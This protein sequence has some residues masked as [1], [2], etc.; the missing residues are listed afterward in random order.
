EL[1]KHTYLTRRG[2]EFRECGQ[3]RIEAFDTSQFI[4]A[5]QLFAR[6][7]SANR[8]TWILVEDLAQELRRPLATPSARF[9]V[10]RN[11]K[12]EAHLEMME[13]VSFKP[14]GAEDRDGAQIFFPEKAEAWGISDD[15]NP[16]VIERATERLQQHFGRSLVYPPGRLNA[17]LME[18]TRD[19]AH[20]QVNYKH[21]PSSFDIFKPIEHPDWCK[22]RPFTEAEKGAKYIHSFDKNAM[23]LQCVGIP[24]SVGNYRRIIKPDVPDQPAPGVWRVKAAPFS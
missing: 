17:Y 12:S 5:D 11:N 1:R 21:P 3:W 10:K 13:R 24:L 16:E 18:G 15:D 9:E 7:Y 22:L 6:L 20:Q 4:N 19:K 23:Y 2:F 8:A 14:C